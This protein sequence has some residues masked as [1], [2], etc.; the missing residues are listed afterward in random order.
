MLKEKA[1]L[2]VQMKWRKFKKCLPPEGKLVLVHIQGYDYMLG[3]LVAKAETEPDSFSILPHS[4]SGYSVE[5]KDCT[6]W[7]L[8]ENQRSPWEGE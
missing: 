4:D 2:E 6:A 5:V 8:F 3:T 7:V 1:G